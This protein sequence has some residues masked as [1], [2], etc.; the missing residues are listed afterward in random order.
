M[1]TKSRN[2]RRGNAKSDVTYVVNDKSYDTY[3]TA[4]AD[5][6]SFALDTG[7]DVTIERHVHTIAA[8]RRLFGTP[9]ADWFRQ[10]TPGTPFNYITIRA[11]QDSQP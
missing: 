11:S 4:C 6:V 8:A 10:L 5:A 9:G 1:P 2:Q 7:E 3:A